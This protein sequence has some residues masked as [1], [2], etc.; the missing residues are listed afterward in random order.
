MDV[1]LDTGANILSAAQGA[2]G[3]SADLLWIKDR[4]NSN[5]H[6]LIDTVRGGTLTL[7][8]N[9]TAAETAYNAPAGSSVAWTWDA[10]TSTVSNTD[11]TITSSVRANPSAGFSIVSY[12]GTGSAVSIGHGLNAKPVLN[13]FKR[14]GASTDW[15]VYTD[16]IDGSWDY[17]VLNSSAAKVNASVFSANSSTF[18]FSSGASNANAS[19]E[20]TIA[21]CFAPVEGYSA[22]GSYEGNGSNTEGP[23]VYCG[24]RPRFFMLKSYTGSRNWHIFDSERSPTNVVNDVLRPNITNGEVTNYATANLLFTSNGVKVNSSWANLNGASDSFIF[25]AFAEHPM[26]YAR[27]R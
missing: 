15:L 24:F 6:Q 20:S 27:A 22:F 3:G 14:T 8:P 4:A 1:V 21:Y 9:N 25:V 13:I 26:K 7:Q 11:G 10:G 12:T 19:G 2:I 23:F 5:N 17:L 18:D 16:T